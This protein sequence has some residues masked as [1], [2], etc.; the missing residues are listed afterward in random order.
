MGGKF[1]MAYF[2]EIYERYQ[3]AGRCLKQKILDEF[4]KVCG[5]N[6]KYAIHKLNGPPPKDQ[7]YFAKNIQHRRQRPT[8][9]SSETIKLLIKVWQAAGYPCSIR[10]KQIIVLWM[11]WIEKHFRP[12]QE[13]K[14]QL[15]A[16]S[17]RQMDRRLQKQKRMVKHRIYGRTKPGTLLKH[18]IPIKTDHWDVKDPGFTEV[19]TVSHSGDCAD[20][21][22]AYSVNQTDILTGWV[23]TRAVLGKGEK[24]VSAAL[25]EM[26][27]DFPFKILGIDSDNG[28]E[29]INYHLVRRCQQRGIQFTRGR[30]YKKD[31]NA[32]VEQ[33]N[34]THVRKLFGWN[35]Y[36]TQTAVD[37]IN[38]LYKNEWHLFMN[39]FMPSTKL[40]QK[41]RIGSKHKRQHDRP[42]T[43]LD[44]LI[45]LNKGD[46]E[47]IANYKKIRNQFDPF[48]LSKSIERK[49]Q[50]VYNMATDRLK[51]PAAA[52][53][54]QRQKTK[55][56]K[57]EQEA[58]K[59]VANIFGIKIRSGGK[60]LTPQG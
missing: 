49:I 15:L 23:E 44:R 24:N 41:T 13:I 10:L 31:D 1:K 17:P 50:A 7:L 27:N 8:I 37:M 53:N 58:L 60:N 22:F 33:K 32:H 39:L 21:L 43:P 20:G 29:F 51:K 18:H 4:C 6:R 2:K 11:P 25:E 47:K 40:I 52:K 3:Q 48:E 42:T 19:D 57:I 59:E 35:R 34:W 45:T 28:S 26:E 16:I 38:N 55:P 12:S 30:P 46:P 9:Y 14:N 36:D 56:G 5:Y 54:K